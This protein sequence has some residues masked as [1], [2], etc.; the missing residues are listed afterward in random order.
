MGKDG[1]PVDMLPVDPKTGLLRVNGVLIGSPIENIPAYETKDKA[2]EAALSFG[3]LIRDK[4]GPNHR[5][6]DCHIKA[7]PHYEG[8][9]A[10]VLRTDLQTR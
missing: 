7:E 6:P 3:W 5:C 2:D 8:R 9:G 4:H 10:Y 1:K